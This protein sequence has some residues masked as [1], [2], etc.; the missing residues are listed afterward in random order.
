[1][2]VYN[3][4]HTCT[5][6][7]PTVFNYGYVHVLLHCLFPHHWHAV[8]MQVPV[9]MYISSIQIN[10]KCD[11][12]D[13]TV[14]MDVYPN[15]LVHVPYQYMYVLQTRLHK[16][17]FCSQRKVIIWTF[18]NFMRCEGTVYAVHLRNHSLWRNMYWSN[19]AG[20]Y[21]N[22]LVLIESKKSKSHIFYKKYWNIRI[23]LLYSLIMF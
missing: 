22:I 1:M 15:N 10:G 7:R 20:Q 23:S 12:I 13:S 9:Y 17:V 11:T 3:P 21:D 18:W 16:C 2:Y 14:S 8:Y 4:V 19:S 5:S 6:V